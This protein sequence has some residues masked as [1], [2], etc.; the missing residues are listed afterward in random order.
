[1]GV[2]ELSEAN[3]QLSMSRLMVCSAKSSLHLSCLTLLPHGTGHSP[4]VQAVG[5]DGAQRG[6]QEKERAHGQLL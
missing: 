1:M 2:E 4:R 5:V 3:K 6:Q